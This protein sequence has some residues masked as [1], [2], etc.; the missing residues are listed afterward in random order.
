[1]PSGASLLKRALVGGALLCL[2]A[3]TTGHL[4]GADSGDITFYGF[5]LVAAPAFTALGTLILSRMPRQPIGW[6]F[7]AVGA[8]AA[9]TVVSASFAGSSAAADWLEVASWPAAIGLIPLLF[10]IFP[11]GRALSSGWL[12]VAWVDLAGLAI[13]VFALATGARRAPGEV[14]DL[15]VELSP[16]AD[17]AVFVATLGLA[18]VLIGATGASV[19]L[20]LRWRRADGLVRQQIR[21]LA[22][23]SLTIPIGMVIDFLFGLPVLWFGLGACVPAAATA[24][25]LSYRL[26]DLDLYLNRTVVYATLTGAILAGYLAVVAITAPVLDARNDNLSPLLATALV[27]VV[28]HPL[29]IVIQRAANRLLYGDRDDPYG[30]LH[31]LNRRLEQEQLTSALPQVLET[32]TDALHVPFAAIELIDDGHRRRVASQGRDAIAAR[33]LSDD[34]SAEDRRQSARQPPIRRLASHGR[35]TTVAARPRGPGRSCDPR[36]A[37]DR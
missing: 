15:E 1:M 24:A 22:L 17:R 35:R 27:A 13:A 33:E 4:T 6:L 21:V 16:A 25:I 11:N 34:L 20:V 8:S 9:S 32:V 28:F 10:L 36:G 14:F 7:V 23:G 19:S 29:R 31:R 5:H 2:A 26:Y 30:V 3:A 12:W 37:A 18:L